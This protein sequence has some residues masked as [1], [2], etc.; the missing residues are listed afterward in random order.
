MTQC[1]VFSMCR[2]L[3]GHFPVCSCLCMIARVLKRHVTVVTKGWDDSVDDASLRQVM[4]E[5][6]ARVTSDD[7]V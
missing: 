4:E 1:T 5:V 3:V 6:L 2:K 7:L